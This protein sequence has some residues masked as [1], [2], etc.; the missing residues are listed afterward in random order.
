MLSSTSLLHG[1]CVFNRNNT[2]A[3]QQGMKT[4]WL[5]KSYRITMCR[6]R[7]ITHQGRV[8][9]STGMHNHPHHMKGSHIAND[10]N[11]NTM[12]V[13]M[14]LAAHMPPVISFSQNHSTS[15][16][17]NNHN[18]VVTSSHQRN[19]HQSN[20]SHNSQSHDVHSNEQNVHH[21]LITN[22]HQ[23]HN[24]TISHQNMMHTV[25]HQNNLM[26]LSGMVPT[27]G[28]I[29]SHAQLSQLNS[30]NIQQSTPELQ[31]T[32]AHATENR[33]RLDSSPIPSISSAQQQHIPSDLNRL[34]QPQKHSAIHS[35]NQHQNH[36]HQI[37]N[38]NSVTVHSP[39]VESSSLSN[40]NQPAIENDSTVHHPMSNELSHSPS[41]KLE[42]I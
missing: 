12:A 36:S 23:H 22:Q 7:C 35:G 19:V 11:G 9:S 29:Q 13:T 16:T 8:I 32:G 1:N 33:Q 25:L 14:R 4:Y 38:M 10:L 30:N 21:S 5:C 39:S 17:H 31:S 18:I 26:H 40:T 28:P 37:E 24:E 20:D 6:A 34:S 15:N 2:V 27:L 42:E 3:T 41:F